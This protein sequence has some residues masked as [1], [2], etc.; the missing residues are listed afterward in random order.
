MLPA[1]VSHIDAKD[2]GSG[3]YSLAEDLGQL[4]RNANRAEREQFWADQVRQL[5]D[6][7]AEH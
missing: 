5:H 1:L 6:Y 7:Y 4:P 2:A 3:F